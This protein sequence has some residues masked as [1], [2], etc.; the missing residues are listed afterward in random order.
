MCQS[1]SPNSSH[2]IPFPLGIHTFVLYLCVSVSAREGIYVYVWLIH[3]AVQKLTQ[4]YS[5]ATILR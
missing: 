2:P 5:K 4:H 1:Q 3:F